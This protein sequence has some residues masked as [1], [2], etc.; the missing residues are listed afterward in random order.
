[1]NEASNP[2][3]PIYSVEKPPSIGE[4]L[5]NKKLTKEASIT[6]VVLMILFF[7][8]L[9]F[10]DSAKQRAVVVETNMPTTPIE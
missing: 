6:D 4:T 9:R 5:N 8:I 10:I 1:M 2:F 3:V 7:G